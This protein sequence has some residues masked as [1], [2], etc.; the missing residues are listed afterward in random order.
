MKTWLAW[1]AGLA[2]GV[3]SAALACD[4]EK[5]QNAL[6]ELTVPQV[7]ELAK[8]GKATLVDANFSEY[9][10]KNGVIPGAILLTSYNEYDAA[11]ELPADKS[12]KLVFYC[13]NKKCGSS[14]FAAARAIHAG[15]TDVNLLPEGLHG[16][17]AAGQPLTQLPRS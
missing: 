2:L 16:W 3:G 15:Y 5:K 14:H 4:G 17:K 9:R 10:A 7:A 6:N 12:A 11:K 8:A 13:A 1:T